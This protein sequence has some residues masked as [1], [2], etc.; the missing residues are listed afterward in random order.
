VSTPCLIGRPTGPAAMRAVYCN[1]DG[2]PSAMVPVLR[3]LVLE[4][5]DG[6]P[7]AAAHYLFAYAGFGY[8]SSL[9][10]SGAAFSPA[11]RA[12]TTNGP[13]HKWTGDRWPEDVDI[14]QDNPECRHAVLEYRDG[15]YLD[16]PLLSWGQQWLYLIY[17]QVL[18]VVRYVAPGETLGNRLPLG[19]NCAALPWADPISV[20]NLLDIER[21]A[22]RRL[23]Q[24][25]SSRDHGRTVAA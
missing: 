10:G 18:A 11:M 4:T 6:R 5:F 16:S 1:C 25:L 12:D 13:I 20:P 2:Y 21:R 7:A 19:I 9:T 15:T 23:D 24:L 22:T 3:R 17:P 8:W 14:Y